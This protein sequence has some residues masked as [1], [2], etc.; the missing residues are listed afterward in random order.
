MPYLTFSVSIRGKA[1]VRG[2][3]ASTQLL[4]SVDS[5]RP[6]PTPSPCIGQAAASSG[7]GG[8][9]TSSGKENLRGSSSR[10]ERSSC[11]FPKRTCGRHPASISGSSRSPRSTRSA[12]TLQLREIV[13]LMPWPCGRMKANRK[14]GFREMRNSAHYPL[15]YCSSRSFRRTDD[16]HQ[17]SKEKDHGPQGKQNGNQPDGRLRR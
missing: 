12:D 9:P 7:G 2:V 6:H 14:E 13:E 16:S 8:A 10:L 11:R 4:Q 15:N 3:R 1:T 17:T 5:C